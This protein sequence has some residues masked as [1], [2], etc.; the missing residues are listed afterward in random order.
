MN[1]FE[2]I[3]NCFV[4]PQ[5][6]FPAPDWLLQGIGDDTARV[7]VPS[8]FVQS[9]SIDTLVCGVHFGSDDDSR[10][11][12]HKSLAVGLSD[13]AASG[14]KPAWA[15]LAITLPSDDPDWLKQ[16]SQGFFELAKLH[17]VHL[18]GGDTT[19]GPLS[20][21]VQVAGWL[22]QA[23]S[24]TRGGAHLGDTIY[25]TGK[26]GLAASALAAK[27][28][29]EQP[30][31]EWLAKLHF[32]EPRIIAGQALLDMATSMIDVS[33]GLVADLCHILTASKVGAELQIKSVP[34]PMQLIPSISSAD[35]IFAALCGGDDYELLFT[36]AASSTEIEQIARSSRTKI[37]AIGI[38]REQA[39]LT[40]NTQGLS[41]SETD[42]VR[43]AET[44]GGYR[45]F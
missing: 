34:R 5:A 23:K 41:E 26:L 18:I 3:Q 45:H 6:S 19:R 42:A 35:S 11:I 10:G 7:A 14:A 28:A 16:F 4:D 33:D 36:S 12:G 44:R 40:L 27:Q 15:S 24:L 25:V 38:I 32:P 39:G 21:T 30:F 17:G 1:E 37:T 9:L 43:R 2:L 31:S 8:G 29:G 22:P 13:L 20:V